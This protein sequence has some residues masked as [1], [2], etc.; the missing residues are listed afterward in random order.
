MIAG[1]DLE[2]R[3]NFECWCSSHSV[4]FK[5]ILRLKL[6]LLIEPDSQTRGRKSGDSRILGGA[7]TKEFLWA[8][9]D[10]ELV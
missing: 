10:H 5:L 1:V 9:I 7:I 2:V 8:I 3:S 6:V 4:A